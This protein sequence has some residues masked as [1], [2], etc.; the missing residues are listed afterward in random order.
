MS[1]WSKSL[2]AGTAGRHLPF[3]LLVAVGLLAGNLG[4]SATAPFS[5]WAHVLWTLV[6]IPVVAAGVRHGAVVAAFIAIAGGLLHLLLPALRQDFNSIHIVGE[7]LVAACVGWT[8]AALSRTLKEQELQ[9]QREPALA[10][11]G[12]RWVPETWPTSVM[13]RVIVGLVRVFGTPVASIEGAGWMLDDP[14]LPEE[15]R[16]EFVGIIRK[17]SQRLSRILAE[18][19]VFTRP[20]P[21]QFQQLDLSAIVDEVIRFAAPK[22]RGPNIL[23]EKNIPA[24]LPRFKGDAEQFRQALLNVVLNAV[25]ASCAGGTYRDLGPGGRRTFRDY[26]PRSRRGHTGIGA[27]THLRPVLHHPGEQPRAG[28]AGRPATSS[29][30]TEV[31]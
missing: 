23:F 27:R 26:R 28:A 5:G 11:S 6:Y 8:A 19:L 15:K 20:R 21:P 29:P 12:T 18:V 4:G 22:D 30:N 10:D 7:T 2:G 16:R 3:V 13:T 25:Q 17:E 14:N 24:G 9:L 1:G 31:A